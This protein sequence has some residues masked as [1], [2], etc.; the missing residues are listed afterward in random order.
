MTMTTDDQPDLSEMTRVDRL[1]HEPARLA[2]MT[3]L[4]GCASASFSFLLKV[5]G[6][7]KGNL[8]RHASRLADAGYVVIDKS[9]HGK[10]PQTTYHLT[11]KGEAAFRAYRS[12][13][14]WILKATGG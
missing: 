6:L 1:V 7:T 4:Y 10:I 9:F 14:R 5:T 2:I 8:S 13:L 11:R 3:A 12:K